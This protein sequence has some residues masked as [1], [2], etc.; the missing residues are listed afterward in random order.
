MQPCSLLLAVRHTGLGQCCLLADILCGP[1]A[2]VCHLL[3]QHLP[4]DYHAHHPAGRLYHPGTFMPLPGFSIAA[5]AGTVLHGVSL[6]ALLLHPWAS[7]ADLNHTAAAHKRCTT[8]PC[9]HSTISAQ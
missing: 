4:A 1:G 9:T 6:C 8:G 2:G 3:E 7:Q 5:D